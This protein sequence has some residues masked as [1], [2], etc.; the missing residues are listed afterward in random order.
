MEQAEEETKMTY[1][2]KKALGA[3]RKEAKAEKDE[4]EKYQRLKVRIM[5]I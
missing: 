1:Q 2:K 3:E 4:A 5:Y